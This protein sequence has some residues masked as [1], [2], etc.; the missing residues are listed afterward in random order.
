MAVIEFIRASRDAHGV[1]PPIAHAFAAAAAL[2]GRRCSPNCLYS[3]TY[4]EAAVSVCSG[5]LSE[6]RKTPTRL[7][8]AFLPSPPS[9]M[10]FAMRRSVPR[11]SYR[12]DTRARRLMEAV[13]HRAGTALLASISLAHGGG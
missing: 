2:F 4:S 6:S 13:P 3:G 8:R 11:T 10:S 1:H 7:E 12:E 9:Q 5:Y